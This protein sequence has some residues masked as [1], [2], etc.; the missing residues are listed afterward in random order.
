MFKKFSILTL[1]TF[2]TS[3]GFVCTLHSGLGSFSINLSVEALSVWTGFSLGISNFIV[4]V[5]M[6]LIAIKKGAGLGWAAIINTITASIFMSIFDIILPSS[7]ILILGI[8]TVPIGWAM[9]GKCGLGH[10]CGNILVEAL[11]KSYNKPLVLIRFIV[12][13]VFLVI[14]YLGVP[15]Y[16]TLTTL[17]ITFGTAPIVDRIYKIF[18]YDPKSI[19]HE[20]I[21]YKKFS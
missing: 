9:I 7:P 1:A 4:E 8:I 21:I 3:F 10:T 19:K 14:A 20:Y 11:M 13:F 16:I 6:L 18:N 15:Q 5:I 17:F 2:L 12:D